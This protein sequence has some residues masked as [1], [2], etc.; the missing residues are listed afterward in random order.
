MG[1][2]AT[3]V[4]ESKPAHMV[5]LPHSLPKRLTLYV[6]LRPHPAADRK[7]TKYARSLWSS[8]KGG[9]HFRTPMSWIIFEDRVG[10]F[11]THGGG[12]PAA[13]VGWGGGWGGAVTFASYCV[14]VPLRPGVGVGVGWGSYVRLLLRACAT[15]PWGWGKGATR[16]LRVPSYLGFLS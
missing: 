10:H 6:P 12:Y 2:Y 11:R 9:D 1:V 14:T 7:A 13:P 3:A 8:E 5:A 16:R 15:A 4:W